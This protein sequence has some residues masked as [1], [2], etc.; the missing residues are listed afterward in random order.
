VFEEAS[1][2]LQH[3]NESDNQLHVT[4]DSISF[5]LSFE[6]K[7]DLALAKNELGSFIGKHVEILRVD[8]SN[9]PIRIRRVASP[10]EGDKPC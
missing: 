4:L 9:S 5:R 8:D 7:A 10:S 1:G 2:P 6:S 3:A